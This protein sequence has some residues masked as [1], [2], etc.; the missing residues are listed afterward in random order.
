MSE[1]LAGS[2]GMTVEQKHFPVGAYLPVGQLDG[3]CSCG[4]G[5]WPCPDA[6]SADRGT[7]PSP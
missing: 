2:V 5:A 4:K 6:P 3:D 1:D 7:D